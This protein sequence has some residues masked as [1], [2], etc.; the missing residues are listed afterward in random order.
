MMTFYETGVEEARSLMLQQP[1]YYTNLT[2]YQ[3]PEGF[4]PV[5]DVLTCS[6]PPEEL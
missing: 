4:G 6:P 1:Y 2:G 3:D 5:N